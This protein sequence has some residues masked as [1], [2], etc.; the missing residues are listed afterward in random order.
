[1]PHKDPIALAAYHVA[2]EASRRGTRS[3]YNAV[4]RAAHR[5]EL[6]DYEKLRTDDGTRRVYAA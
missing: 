2:Y 4:W 5:N 3:A 1:M 6:R